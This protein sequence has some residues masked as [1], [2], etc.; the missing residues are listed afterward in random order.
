MRRVLG[1]SRHE[2]GFWGNAYGHGQGRVGS[3]C[4]GGESVDRQRWH[5][6]ESRSG[7]EQRRAVLSAEPASRQLPSD[8]HDQGIP[9][10]SA[11]WHH[12]HGWID[13][14]AQHQHES[15]RAHPEGGSNCGSTAGAN[16]FFRHSGR[17]RFSDGEGIAAQRSRLGV[18]GRAGAGREQSRE[19]GGN[20]VQRQQREPRLWQPVDGFRPP[21]Q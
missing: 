11:K 1:C 6:C 17:R 21:P 7:S 2:S 4:R 16:R 15:W 3:R 18:T 9:D 20:G 8:D 13:T 14:D 12:A 19:P 5:R 10:L